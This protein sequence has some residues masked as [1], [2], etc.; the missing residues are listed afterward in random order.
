M[1]QNKKES[2]YAT[3]ALVEFEDNMKKGK[4]DVS[5]FKKS[6]SK[7]KRIV[8]SGNKDFSTDQASVALLRAYMVMIVKMMPILEAKFFKTGRGVYEINN[9]AALS[10]ELSNI[11]R[12]MGDKTEQAQK[13]MNLAVDPKLQMI[14][15]HMSAEHTLMK[16]EL[17]SMKFTPRQLAQIKKLLNRSL[18]HHAEYVSENRAGINDQ[19]IKILGDVG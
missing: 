12:A 18:R 14:T 2:K 16:R 10:I 7:L 1:P 8:G 11:L 17:S 6:Y 9:L 5:S 19:I 3:K 13:V 4:L 15:Q